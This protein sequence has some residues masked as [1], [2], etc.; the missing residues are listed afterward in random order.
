MNKIYEIANKC[1]NFINKGIDCCKYLHKYDSR[2]YSFTI[3]GDIKKLE[4]LLWDLYFVVKSKYPLIAQ[5]LKNNIEKYDNEPVVYFSAIES[6]ID[7]LIAIESQMIGKRIFI[8]H[9]SKDKTIVEAFVD[10]ILCLGIGIDRNDIFCTSIEDLAISNGEDIRKHIQSTIRSAE[11][12]FL[13]ISDNYKSSEIC[14]NEMG[15]VWAYDANVRTYLLPNS[16]FNDIGWLN[17]PRKAD[18]IENRVALDN[19]YEEMQEF[20]SIKNSVKTWGQQKEAFIRL[21]DK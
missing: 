6:I 4:E 10:H 5:N 9:S 13:L 21:L 7:C 12:S 1:R 20:Y 15:A 14:I 17:D 16:D 8:S 3:E 11:Y 2:F 19:L 18:K